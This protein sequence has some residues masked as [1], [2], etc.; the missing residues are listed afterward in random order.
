MMDRNG[1]NIPFQN[2]G[3]AIGEF[4]GIAGRTAMVV[5]RMSHGRLALR[6]PEGGTGWCL[7]GTV[8]EQGESRSIRNLAFGRSPRVFVSA[9]DT[10]GT[11]R[12][13]AAPG[14]PCRDCSVSCR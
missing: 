5:D 4:V 6:L 14:Q 9:G 13:N 10:T 12:E 3:T 1:W 2:L 11:R 7:F 8:V